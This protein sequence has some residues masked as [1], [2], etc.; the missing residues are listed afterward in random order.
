[1]RLK[2]NGFAGLFAGKSRAS[3]PIPRNPAGKP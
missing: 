1:L 3:L 2:S